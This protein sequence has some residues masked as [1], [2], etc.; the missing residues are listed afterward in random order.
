MLVRNNKHF[1]LYLSILILSMQKIKNLFIIAILLLSFTVNAQCGYNLNNYTNIIC[2]GDNT[3]EIDV[4]ILN[5]N[6]S[7]WWSGPLG[8]SASTVSLTALFS[9]DYVLHIMENQIP[10]DTSSA[11]IC[12]SKNTISISQTLPIVANFKLSNMCLPND[13]VDVET[14]ILGG[15]PPYTTLW[16]TG[17][18]TPSTTSLAP[19]PF[20][21]TLSIIDAN[22]CT[23][24]QFLKIENIPLMNSFMSSVGVICKDDNSGSARVFITNGTSP[25]Q[26][27]WSTDSAFVIEHDSFSVLPNL[28]PGEYHVKVTDAMDCVI[29]DTILVKSN[30][31]ICITVYKVFSPNDDDVH[32]FW[33]IKNIH[34]YPE[35]LVQVYDRT[36]K[37]VYSRRSYINAEEV[38]FSGKDQQGRTLPS[39]TYYYVIDLEN[40]DTV[41]KG[42]LTIVR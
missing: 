34:L 37:K 38:A 20:P 24:T 31:L 10:G 26:F 28:F 8:F 3:G 18:P 6:S 1:F 17:D 23:S 40:E 9:G 5:S 13:S 39:G 29:R 36:G 15:T 4:T 11:V 25:F 30:P 27:Q 35:A 7:F 19:N 2:N 41:F 16:S 32:E 22:N 21:Y 14:T 42:V 33:E 12:Y